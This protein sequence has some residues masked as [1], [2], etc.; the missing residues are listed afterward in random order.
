M[1]QIATTYYKYFSMS[2]GTSSHPINPSSLL[3][4]SFLHTY[5]TIFLSES[6]IVTQFLPVSSLCIVCIYRG[7]KQPP[8]EN[9]SR[10]PFFFQK[11]RVMN[12]EPTF[13][14]LSIA[15]HFN[16]HYLMPCPV[17]R[18]LFSK[19]EGNSR[20]EVVASNLCCN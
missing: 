3:L 6:C 19:R 5:L 20:V 8:T 17:Q 4:P 9:I 11:E 10:A 2:E 13:S 7:T 15:T 12:G 16:L 14:F 1:N 18:T